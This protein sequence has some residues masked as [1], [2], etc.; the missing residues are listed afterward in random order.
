MRKILSFVIATLF[1]GSMFA[2]TATT[3]YYSVPATTVGSYNVRLNVNFQGDGINVD[4]SLNLRLV[5]LLEKTGADWMT[6]GKKITD[7]EQIKN[8]AT[9]K[10]AMGLR[11][12]E[13]CGRALYFSRSAV[14]FN[15]DDKPEYNFAYWHIG[16]YVYKRKALEAFVKSPV[17]VLENMI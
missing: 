13:E 14:P 17:G 5:D 9:V 16:I 15:R 4:P 3:V 7:P 8:P 10:I 2:A 6:V 1:A 11:E 12:G